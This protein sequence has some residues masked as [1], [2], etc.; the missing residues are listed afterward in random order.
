M[1]LNGL[2]KVV[3]FSLHDAEAGTKTNGNTETK[4]LEGRRGG[5]RERGER[6]RGGD[7]ERGERERGGGR[8]RGER[9]RGGD[10]EREGGRTL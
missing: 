2:S 7:R 5:G 1:C 8:E 6:E 9:E 4:E 10:R 3:F